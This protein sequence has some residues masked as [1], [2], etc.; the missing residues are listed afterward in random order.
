M[1][2]R[3]TSNQKIAGSS[4][5]AGSLRTLSFSFFSFFFF[6]FFLFLFL[7]LFSFFSFLLLFWCFL[8]PF[9]FLFFLLLFSSGGIH[10]IPSFCACRAIFFSN[11]LFPFARFFSFFCFFL[12]FCLLLFLDVSPPS[13]LRYPVVFV[14][15]PLLLFVWFC[16]SFVAPCVCLVSVRSLVLP[17]LLLFA[18]V[19]CFC[20]CRWRAA[21]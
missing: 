15:F 11:C 1:A 17:L 14:F 10:I 13:P 16:C 8:F 2:T 18:V 4:P 21:F 5:V 9:F 3:L 12:L 7:L 6:L 19:F 20:F